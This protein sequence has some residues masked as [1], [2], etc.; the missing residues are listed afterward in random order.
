MWTSKY[1]ELY[2]FFL[3]F[4]FM[5]LKGYEGA[6][7][8]RTGDKH[9]GCATFW[10][11]SKFKVEKS[12]PVEYFKPGIH[13]LDRDNV[14]LL[15]LLRPKGKKVNNKSFRLCIANTH[16]LFNPR[17]GD[18][19]LAQAML[20]MAE[21]EKLSFIKNIPKTGK[22]KYCPTLLCGDFNCEPFCDLYKFFGRGILNYDGLLQRTISGQQE[23]QFGKDYYVSK[24]VV[25][26]SIGI[27]DKCQYIE[28]LCTRWSKFTEGLEKSTRQASAT[29]TCPVE[30]EAVDLNK[31]SAAETEKSVPS[32]E[33]TEVI[34]I[35]DDKSSDETSLKRDVREIIKE[36]QKDNQIQQKSMQEHDKSAKESQH[37]DDDSVVK[38]KQSDELAKKAEKENPSNALLQEPSFDQCTGIL[39]H[40]ARFVS[41][42][43]HEYQNGKHYER[44]A[45]THHGRANCTVDYIFYTVDSRQTRTHTCK[46]K[47]HSVKEGKLQLIAKLMLASE[48]KLNSAGCLPNEAVSSDHTILMAKFE[49]D[50]G[51]K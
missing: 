27:N 12:V 47:Y 19:K 51:K 31:E 24:Q 44:E 37:K 9:D 38:S 42:Y 15:V 2:K 50:T 45:T 3:R 18:I 13:V 34:D 22:E 48:R 8:K 43:K 4:C 25:P 33:V 32:S 21:I 29:S 14:A 40:K 35:T 23:G 6:F 1:Q 30:A 16:L 28:E 17:R 10:K 49:L 39:S 20:L 5:Y 41:V 7:K 36:W 11:D 46:F 26:P